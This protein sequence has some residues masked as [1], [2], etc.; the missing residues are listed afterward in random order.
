[1][2][3]T[4]VAYEYNNSYINIKKYFVKRVYFLGILIYKRKTEC[5]R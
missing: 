2:I 5:S 1:M 3:Y 4:T